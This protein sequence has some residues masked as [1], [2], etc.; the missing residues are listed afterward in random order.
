MNLDIITIGDEILI[1][2]IVD[3]NSAWMAQK[4]NDE[5][6]NVRQII[7]IS[8]DPVH[9]SETFAESAKKVKLVLVTGGLG[10]TKDD[11]TKDTICNFFNTSLIENHAVLK[12]VEE[13][14]NK[15]G[16]A[17]NKL[18]RDQALVPESGRVFQNKLGTAP[19]LL[20]EK[21]G[22]SF[23]FMPGVPYEMKYL[24]EFEILPYLRSH[25]QTSTILHRTVLTQGLP[26]SM[27]AEKIAVWEDALPEYIKLAYLPSPQ[28]VRLRLS[29]RG[30]D[31][32]VMKTEVENR[33]SSLRQ[34]IDAN[35]YGFDDESPAER[36]GNL[37]TEK[38][39]TI[40]T[41]E[42]CTGGA[43]ARL[44][45]ENPGSSAYFKGSVIAYSNE[46][47]TNVLG[48]DAESIVQHGAVSRAVVESMAIQAIKLMNTDFAVAT[49]GIAGPGGG[50]EEKPVGTVWIAVAYKEQVISQLY[51]FGNDRERNIARTAQNALFL[52]RKL[53]VTL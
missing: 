21:D 8:D 4:L 19:G 33:I 39:W 44:F 17:L 16:I 28:G 12:N 51:N 50:T 2:Q 45:T 25:F 35:I 24:M 7:S 10:P 49:S 13:L 36:I 42:S 23:V 37:L 15:R 32:I 20:L 47:K 27:L 41:A 3:T 40:S 34:L 22:C 6:I 29:A 38:R 46:V 53:L 11:K 43:I 5:G 31:L 1:G 30:K 18:N 48:V 9:I 26:E 52:L 14:L